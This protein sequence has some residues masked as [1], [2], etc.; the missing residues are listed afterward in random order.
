MA[1]TLLCTTRTYDP[2]EFM[3]SEK[4]SSIK[5]PLKN[6]ENCEKIC[7]NKNTK[8]TVKSPLQETLA[9]VDLAALQT[10]QES[11][12]PPLTVPLDSPSGEGA[13]LI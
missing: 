3:H 2:V 11:D 13:E 4:N 5:V 1:T 7:K 6:E 8:G 12:L 9:A 10:P